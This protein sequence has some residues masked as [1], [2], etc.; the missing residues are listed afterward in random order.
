MPLTLRALFD[1]QRQPRREFSG[2]WRVL[3]ML[4]LGFTIVLHVFVALRP[5][6]GPLEL[7][8]LHVALFLSVLFWHYPLSTRI[9]YWKALFLDAVLVGV[10]L[11]CFGYVFFYHEEIESRIPFVSDIE[12]FQV[13]LGILA[14][15]IVME[16]TRRVVGPILPG[17]V[18]L[19]VGYAF[20]GPAPVGVGGL[21][22]EM[23]VEHMYLL[24]DGIFGIPTSVSAKY[25]VLFVTP[26]GAA[27]GDGFR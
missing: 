21:T 24:T 19:V 26:G 23:L 18:L 5:L 14:M 20:L 7:R 12:G 4:L 15:L 25:V 2:G 11:L 13:G 3:S 8:A 1:F 6:A 17:I 9:S 22:V 10:T 16:A 27:D